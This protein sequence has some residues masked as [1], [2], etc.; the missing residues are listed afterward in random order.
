MRGY[1]GLPR[2]VGGCEGAEVRLTA[3]GGRRNMLRAA[4]RLAALRGRLARHTNALENKKRPSD[5]A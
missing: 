3:R 2:A 5:Y 1:G 4:S